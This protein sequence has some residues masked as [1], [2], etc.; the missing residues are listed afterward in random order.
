MRVNL[1]AKTSAGLL[2]RSGAIPLSLTIKPTCGVEGMFEYA[3]DSTSLLRML[4]NETDL[5]GAVIDRFRS[6]LEILTDVRL[7]GVAL[8]DEV[9]EQVGFFID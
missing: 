6:E 1:F 7:L 5:N 2:N 9:L 4:R 3:T 8:K